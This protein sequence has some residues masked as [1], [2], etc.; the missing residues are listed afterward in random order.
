V[1]TRPSLDHARADD[2]F[3]SWTMKVQVMTEKQAEEAWE[4]KRINVFDLTHI[5]PH[6]DYPLRTIGKFTLNENAK[7][8]FFHASLQVFALTF[9]TTLPKLNRSPSTP[10]TWS[11]V[12]NHP[13]TPSSSPDY[14]PTPMPTDTESEPTT[15]SCPST[16]RYAPSR[17]ATSS[18]MVRWHSTTRVVDQTT[19]PRSSQSHSKRGRTT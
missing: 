10:R 14:S 15:S 6:G 9:R 19:F 3:P 7:V 16:S 1:S 18:E 5:W 12:S 11:P 8:C 13:T 17:W 4:Q 2:S